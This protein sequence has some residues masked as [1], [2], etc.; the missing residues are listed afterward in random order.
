MTSW[1]PFCTFSFAALSWSQFCFDFLQNS[2]RGRMLSCTVCHLKSA[3]SVGNMADCVFE[4]K[5]KWLIKTNFFIIRQLRCLFSTYIDPPITNL[6]FLADWIRHFWSKWRNC[7][8]YKV[9]WNMT[10]YI[11]KAL[12]LL[13]CLQFLVVLTQTEEFSFVDCIN[14]IRQVRQAK[15]VSIAVWYAVIGTCSR[16]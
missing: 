7:Q 14:F 9:S 15:K 2:R 11:V 10:E 1:L 16:L 12:I 8:K 13:F 4:K 3:R 6:L 5:S